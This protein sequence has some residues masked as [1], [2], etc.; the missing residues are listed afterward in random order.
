MIEQDEN[1]EDDNLLILDEEL[2]KERMQLNKEKSIKKKL[3][4]QM[5]SKLDYDLVK[6]YYLKLKGDETKAKRYYVYSIFSDDDDK[7]RIINK[8]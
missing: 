2:N 8:F 6:R 4:N 7:N 3:K 5:N 1:N